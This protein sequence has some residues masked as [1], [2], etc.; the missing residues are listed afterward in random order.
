MGFPTTILTHNSFYVRWGK[1]IFDLTL[2]SAALLILAPMFAVVALGVWAFL[3]RPVVFRQERPGRAG[4]RFTL[5]KFRTM[6]D[7]KGK[8]GALRSDGERL[9]RFGRLVRSSSLD[10]LPELV[11]VVRGEMSLVGPRPL[12]VR[13]FPY[14]RVDELGRFSVRPGITGLAQVEGRNDLSWDGRIGLDLEYVQR[15]SLWLD[16]R[17]LACTVWRVLWRR[18]VQ[19]DPGAVMLDFDEERRRAGMRPRTVGDA[20]E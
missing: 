15:C 5:F 11:N 9:T 20:N 12:L 10:E 7:T 18:G 4:R 2:A 17:I 14:F 19:I 13:Y 3:G 8:D 1:R 16:I 6:T